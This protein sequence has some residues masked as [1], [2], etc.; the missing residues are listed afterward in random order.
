MLIPRKHL[1]HKAAGYKRK[2]YKCEICGNVSFRDYIP[3]SSA[4]PILCSPCGH[5]DYGA[6]ERLFRHK[7]I[8]EKMAVY[9]LRRRGLLA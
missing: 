7:E 2:W 4:N 5:D 8:S 9:L 3:Y 6:S 1:P